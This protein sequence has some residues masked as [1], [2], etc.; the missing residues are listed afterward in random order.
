M[1]NPEKIFCT[2]TIVIGFKYQ[3]KACIWEYR[4]NLQSSVL[5]I[6]SNYSVVSEF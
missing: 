5:N 4:T 2:Q 6:L 1:K 3:C